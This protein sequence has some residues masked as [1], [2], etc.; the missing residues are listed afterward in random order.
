MIRAVLFDMDGTVLD[1]ERMYYRCYHLA[2]DDVGF[3]GD[4]NQVL[5]DITGMTSEGIKAYFRERYGTDF[6]VEDLLACWNRRVDAVIEA[7]GVPVKPGVP[8][9]FDELHRDGCFVALVSST[10]RARVTRMLART[11][12]DRHFDLVVTG[13]EVRRGK[14]APDI[15]LL[16]AERLGVLPEECAVAEDSANGARAGIAAGM[17]TVV[18]PDQIPCPEELRPALW[19]VLPTLCPLPDMIRERNRQE[20]SKE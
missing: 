15:F 4:M 6:P 14:P 11:G 18:V 12:I 8:E 9:I 20:T 10:R 17:P 2:G 19:E 7:E 1:S 5:R 3:T 13:E 16:A